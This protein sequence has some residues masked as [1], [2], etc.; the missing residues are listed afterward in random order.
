MVAELYAST[1]GGGGGGGGSFTPADATPHHGQASSVPTNA[2]TTVVSYLVPGGFI[3]RLTQ[4]IAT[5]SAD[6]EWYVYDNAV[7]VARFRTSGA[8]RSKEVPFANPIPFASGHT[9]S[10]KAAHREAASQNFYATILGYDG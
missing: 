4:V 10:V 7:E 9:V 8:E 1:A 3:F 6:A 2:E 5:G